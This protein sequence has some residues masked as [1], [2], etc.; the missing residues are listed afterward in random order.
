MDKEIKKLTK[1]TL[2]V[3][4]T[5]LMILSPFYAA[6]NTVQASAQTP[7]YGGTLNVGYGVEPISFNPIANYWSDQMYMDINIYSKPHTFDDLYNIIGDAMVDYPTIT[8]EPG[9]PSVYTMTL[10][11][12]ILFHDGTPMTTE[13][14]KFTFE[15][16][17]WGGQPDV[18][19]TEEIANRL[20]I[21][22]YMAQVNWGK[23]GKIEIVDDYTIKFYFT[24]LQLDTYLVEMNSNCILPKHIWENFNK[25]NPAGMTAEDNEMN[26]N[27]IG[28]GPFMVEEYVPEQY[29]IMKRFDDYFYGTPYLENIVFNILPDPVSA[30]LALENGEID[31]FHENANF[32]QAEIQRINAMAEFTAFGFPY[33]TTWRV[34]I[35][36]HPDAYARWPWLAD[37]DVLKAMEY[38]ID[39][40]T[41]VS[42]VLF[43]ITQVTNT[44]ISWI[45]APYGGDYNSVDQGYD[46]DWP[47]E[48]RTY[49]PDKARQLL[50]DAGW[51]L[52]AD[53]VR[54]KDGVKIEGTTAPYY[55]YATAWSE[56]C[57]GYWEEVGI[58][59]EPIPIQSGVFFE[60]LEVPFWHEDREGEAW[61]DDFIGEKVPTAEGLET[62]ELGG[63]FPVSFNTMGAGPD[64]DD[65]RYHIASWY[66]G[67]NNFG[68]Y[69]NPRVDELFDMGAG[70]TDYDTRKD[71]Y[72]EL[73][74]LLHEDVACIWLWN[75]WKIKAYSNDFAGF[76]TNLPIAWYGR[77]FRGD[78]KSTNVDRGVYWKQG[79]DTPEPD[80]P[81]FMDLRVLVTLTLL[82][83]TGFAVV[84][85]RRKVN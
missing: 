66:P 53:G 36:H 49:D 48:F 32:P 34:R 61:S 40:E 78:D 25:D 26:M 70:T 11:D 37:K 35:N 76:G 84:R 74:F 6:P 71:I 24:E 55:H 83:L 72:D 59:I 12:N 9:Y 75:K 1:R 43:G 80:V 2:L 52:N 57:T 41:I 18:A 56:A 7:K 33:T 29:V 58:F 38:A 77:Y 15:T 8:S 63:P 14:I 19:P 85:R 31:H 44:G 4:V 5:L 16:I 69:S 42:E 17:A 51:V 47:I 81:E 10:H 27:P 20:T 62:N 30:L 46:G 79:T 28:S 73:Q 54:E 68:F 64:P 60:T 23:L 21:P 82:G 13:D 50:D 39:K 45:V 22:A 65:I 67:S 3:T